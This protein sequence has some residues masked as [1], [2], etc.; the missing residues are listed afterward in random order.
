MYVFLNCK[1]FPIYFY[2]RMTDDNDEKLNKRKRYKQY[3][4]PNYN[5]N[6]VSAQTHLRWSHRSLS[7][8]FAGLF[9]GI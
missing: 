2:V 3:L 7:A 4:E 9:N 5:S 6:E 8:S 1:H